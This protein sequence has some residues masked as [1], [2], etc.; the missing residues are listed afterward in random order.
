MDKRMNALTAL[1]NSFMTE[2]PI[3]YKTSLWTGFYMI[4]TSVMKDL[5]KVRCDFKKWT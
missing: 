2:V 5:H 1:F 4:G 3:T